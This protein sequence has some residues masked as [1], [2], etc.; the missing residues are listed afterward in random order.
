GLVPG[1]QKGALHK[2]VPRPR[3]FGRL[4]KA[5]ADEVKPMLTIADGIVAMEGDGPSSGTPVAL[6]ILAAS[7]D[8]F[9]LD[10]RLCDL[11][12]IPR[13]S[14]PYLRPLLDDS[15]YASLVTELPP[16]WKAL[17]P[18]RF[19]LPSTLKTRLIPQWAA[20]LISPLLWIR[21]AF[22]NARCVRCGRCA[23]ACPMDI[24][25]LKVEGGK[26]EGVPRLAVPS[27]CIGCC[28]CHELC[29]VKAVAMRQSPLLRLA[30][31]MGA[32][33]ERTLLVD[34]DLRRPQARPVKAGGGFQFDRDGKDLT[35]AIHRCVGVGKCRA[36]TQATGGFMCPS[37]QASKDERHVTRGRARVLQEATNGRL[38]SGLTAKEVRESLDLCLSC[39]A[40]SADC[41]AGV[42]I[43]AFKSEVLHRT[44]RNRLRPRDHY[45]LGWLPRW[46][47]LLARLRL[48]IPA[49]NAAL[50]IRPLARLVLA[51]GGLD[52]RRKLAAFAPVGF[53]HWWKRE[54]AVG[55]GL[56]PGDGPAAGL[57]RPVVLWVDSFSDGID[58]A[59]PQAAVELLRR[60]GYDVIVPEAA[61]CCGL[62]WISTGQLDGAKRQLSHLMGVLAPYATA[63]IPIMGLEPSCTGVLRSDLGHLFPDDPRAHAIGAATVTLA[64]LLTDPS[65]APD[66]QV[67]QMP[68]LTGVTAVVQPHCH[69]HSVMGFERDVALLEAAG[70]S[71]QV[72]AGCCGLAGNF[73]MQ[74]GHYDMSVAVAEQALLPALRAAS[75]DTIY[76]ADGFSCRTQAEQLAGVRGQAL[77]Q[78]L[79]E[80][81]R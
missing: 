44:Y 42:D 15:A 23:K 52:A 43:A 74:R 5:I 69:H 38:I 57:R 24:L 61:A 81:T 10:M 40:C 13:K 49:V 1:Y 53:R 78:L 16:E 77:A 20:R 34:A 54:G 33:G 28:C 45:V 37:Y 6:G 46:T 8:P 3:D 76:L 9:A 35:R 36:D 18:L 4:V 12:R 27:K 19:K 71:L 70:A 25:R 17:Q 29:P 51:V 50:R 60:A 63:G 7:E 39:K 66:P 80:K 64:E 14:V 11:L 48:V 75:A 59:V 79:A 65:T 32:S 31:A 72:L 58:P 47:R 67:W 22:D 55:Q 73:G 30:R 26:A 41:P 68:D 2:K 62:T 56:P 21:P